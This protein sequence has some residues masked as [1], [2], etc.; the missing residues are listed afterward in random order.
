VGDVLRP[1]LRHVAPVSVDPRNARP[2]LLVVRVLDRILPFLL[3]AHRLVY[4]VPVPRVFRAARAVVSAADSSLAFTFST[5]A[6]RSTSL[7]T[8][9]FRPLTFRAISS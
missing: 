4:R 2:V 5:S 3:A 9:S 7:E 6:M 1:R 8:V